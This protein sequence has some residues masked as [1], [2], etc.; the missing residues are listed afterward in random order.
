VVMI[1]A[2]RGCKSNRACFVAVDMGKRG[3]CSM[4]DFACCKKGPPPFKLAAMR[5]SRSPA[6]FLGGDCYEKG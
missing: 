1:V 5:Q 3:R 6:L 2:Y 4:S